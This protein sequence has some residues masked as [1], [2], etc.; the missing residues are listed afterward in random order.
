MPLQRIL[1]DLTVCSGRLALAVLESRG[2]TAPIEESKFENVYCFEFS[3]LHLAWDIQ[4][5]QY[6]NM[7]PWWRHQMETFSALLVLCEG[8][9]PITGEFPSHRPVTQS[10]DIFFDLHLNK[11]LRKQSRRRWFDAGDLRHHRAHYSVCRL[12]YDT[13][14]EQNFA[15][16]H[17][18][19][20]NARQMP[21]NLSS[22]AV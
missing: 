21:S 15:I 5:P 1:G 9:S 4:S 2:P 16:Y 3:W 17:L 7:V 11:R 14:V 10:F 20:S 22:K 19:C 13:E 12:Y 8:I 6:H 18:S